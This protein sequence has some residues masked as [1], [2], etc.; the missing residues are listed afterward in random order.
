MYD[1]SKVLIP[2]QEDIGMDSIPSNTLGGAPVY[3]IMDT[4]TKEISEVI[5]NKAK[6]MGIP[7]IKFV[8][9]QTADI[10]FTMEAC[11]AALAHMNRADMTPYKVEE[12]KV[13]ELM[14]KYSRGTLNVLNEPTH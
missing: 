5:E 11:K 4:E 6:M 13:S 8:I 9:N 1:M 2:I 3:Y 12:E 10:V 7:P 14:D